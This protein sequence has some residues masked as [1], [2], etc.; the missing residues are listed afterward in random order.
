LNGGS[1]WSQV[2]ASS[3]VARASHRRVASGAEPAGRRRPGSRHAAGFTSART[4]GSAGRPRRHPRLDALHGSPLRRGTRSG[5]GVAT[6]PARPSIDRA[7]RALLRLRRR[8]GSEPRQ[9]GRGRRPRR[10][11]AARASGAA[12]ETSCTRFWRGP[13]A[14]KRASIHVRADGETVAS[15]KTGC[16]PGAPGRTAPACAATHPERS[17]PL[18]RVLPRPPMQA[19]RRSLRFARSAIAPL[20][21]RSRWS[22]QRGGAAGRAGLARACGA[23]ARRRDRRARLRSGQR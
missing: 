19:S 3:E 13:G 6:L 14:V 21:S 17:K 20:C 7:R 18:A 23:G 8:I 1:D 16:G 22:R 5:S 11:L 9:R 12:R 10:V 15:R 2:T 4:P